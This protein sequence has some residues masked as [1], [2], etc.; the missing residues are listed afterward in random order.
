MR[1]VSCHDGETICSEVHVTYTVSQKKVYLVISAIILP[2]D[3][4]TWQLS[5]T[6]T[7]YRVAQKS[8]PLSRIIIKSY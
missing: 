8:K 2:H 5:S 7:T 1:F 6:Y 3:D 4:W